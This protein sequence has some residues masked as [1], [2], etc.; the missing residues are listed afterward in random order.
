[1]YISWSIRVAATWPSIMVLNFSSLDAGIICTKWN[2]KVEGNKKI[3]DNLKTTVIVVTMIR[4]IYCLIHKSSQQKTCWANII[5][6]C[7]FVRFKKINSRRLR[8]WNEMKWKLVGRVEWVFLVDK[9]HGFVWVIWISF[10]SF[11]HFLNTDA[12]FFFVFT[13]STS[14]VKGILSWVYKQKKNDFY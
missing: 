9:R 3:K 4:I 13:F 14:F 1:M 5:P 2:K 10:F 8:K 12:I 7:S 6:K 11:S